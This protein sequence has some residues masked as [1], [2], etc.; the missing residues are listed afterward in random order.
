MAR[1]L[2]YSAPGVRR[3]RYH[4]PQPRRPRSGQV[5]DAASREA[6]HS[7][8][9]SNRSIDDFIAALE[10][11][12]IETLADVRSYPVSRRYPHFSRD[13]LS[14]ALA[15]RGI[16]ACMDAAPR[17]ESARADTGLI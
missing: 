6:G 15:A 11:H 5:I 7:I 1:C 13:E 4:A 10:A 12:G 17:R 9:H 8:G 16:K 2:V 3:I 14:D